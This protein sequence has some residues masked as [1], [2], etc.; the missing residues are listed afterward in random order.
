MKNRLFYLIGV[1]ALLSYTGTFTS[2]VNGVDDEYLEQQL[3]GDSEG[4][5][6]TEEIPDLNGDYGKGGDYDLIMTCNGEELGGKLVSFATD[7]NNETATIILTGSEVDMETAIAGAIPG[8]FGGLI[9]G[10]GLKY[11]SNSPIPGE[12]EITIPNIPLFKN[13]TS[14]KFDGESVQP[15]YTIAYRGTIEGDKMKIDLNYELTNQKLAGTWNTAPVVGTTTNDNVAALAPLWFDFASN[16][17]VDLGKIYILTVNGKKVNGILNLLAG[18]TSGLVM[19][20]VI[21]SGTPPLEQ[22]VA[23]LLRDITAKSNGGMFATYSYSGDLK[24]PAWSSE[25]PHNIMRYYFDVDQPDKRIYL[26]VNSDFLIGMIGDLVQ[27]AAREASPETTKQ[28][29]RELVK[30]M[31]PVLQNGIP[32]DYVLDGDHLTINIDGVL[33]RDILAKIMELVN[34]EY[35]KPYVEEFLTSLGDFKNNLMLLFATLPNALKYH[36]YDKNT[37]TYS[38]EC[39]YFKMGLKFVKK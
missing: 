20:Q 5:G 24:N 6:E 28:I 27:P 36:D 19:G 7:E 37:N 25:M 21:G 13:G 14:Y 3:L 11:T 1:A 9:S 10:L 32:C 4:S 34:D 26:E 23:N 39:E 17:P 33:M 29:G 16:V 31:V 18:A 12:K 38:G 35:A 30:I 15:T 22:I 2:C 8:G